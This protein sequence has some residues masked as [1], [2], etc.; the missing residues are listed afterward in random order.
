ME[1]L[2]EVDTFE[3][4]LKLHIST[5]IAVRQLLYPYLTKLKI[6]LGMYLSYTPPDLVAEDWVESQILRIEMLERDLDRM[7]RN[8]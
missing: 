6:N 4:T 7:A 5:I 1:I 3:V 2:D 8:D